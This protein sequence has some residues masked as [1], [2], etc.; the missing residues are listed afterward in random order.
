MNTIK[1]LEVNGQVYGLE[2]VNDVYV[3]YTEP[4]TENK[5]RIW[6]Q[7]SGVKNLI[8]GYEMS[9]FEKATG[10]TNYHGDYMLDA[11]GALVLTTDTTSATGVRA[12]EMI[13]I[14]HES[15]YSIRF[16]S[17]GF[18]MS[19]ANMRT[20]EIYMYDINKAF[21]NK[22]TEVIEADTTYQEGQK[23]C[24]IQLPTGVRYIRLVIPYWLIDMYRDP[25][26]VNDAATP[27]MEENPMYGG[28]KFATN[29]EYHYYDGDHY[30]T[31]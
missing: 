30:V 17:S 5:P 3:G 12:T 31:L 14:I 22:T 19:E 4:A 1:E 16:G 24:D 11:N 25:A 21:I 26:L 15:R 6:I 9:L 23:I 7:P 27:H 8:P 2:S 20:F 28:S 13:A 29:I 18:T 10:S